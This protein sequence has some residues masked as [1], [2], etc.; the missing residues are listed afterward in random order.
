MFVGCP[1][2]QIVKAFAAH[3]LA[4]EDQKDNANLLLSRFLHDEAMV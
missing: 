2:P 3:R 1:V 4:I